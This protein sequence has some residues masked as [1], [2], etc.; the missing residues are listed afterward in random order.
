MKP[1]WPSLLPAGMH[2]LNLAGLAA[3]T[4]AEPCNT[5]IRIDL[6]AR[7]QLYLGQ[8]EAAGASGEVWIDGSFLTHKPDPSDI[9]LALFLDDATLVALDSETIALLDDLLDRHTARERYGIDLYME[10]SGDFHRAAYWRGVFGFCHDDITP[11]GIA[12]L[13]FNR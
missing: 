9:D 12:V 11:K 13:Q 6:Y 2:G 8:I 1:D 7:L 5:S 10:R 4:L 3:L